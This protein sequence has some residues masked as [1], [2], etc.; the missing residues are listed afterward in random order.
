[1]LG[2]SRTVSSLCPKVIKLKPSDQKNVCNW[3]LNNQR[4]RPSRGLI[5]PPR[6]GRVWSEIGGETCARSSR[7][8]EDCLRNPN[9]LNLNSWLPAEAMEKS[10][11]LTEVVLLATGSF[12]PITVMHLRLFELARDYLHGTGRYKVV[13]GIIS[14]VSDGYKKKG[15]VE[16]S[17]RLTM[18]QLAAESS[19]WIEVDVW[20]CSQKEWTETVL[21]HHQQQQQQLVCANSGR[22]QKKP[23]SRKGHKRKRDNSCQDV[24]DYNCP[25]SKATPQVKLLCGADMLESLGTPNLWKPE[26]VVEIVSSFG[27]VCIARLGSDARKFIYESDVLWKYKDN[28]HLVEEWITN[29]ISST[30]VRR[31]LRRGLSVRYLVPD[32]VL[33]YIQAH[34]LYNEESEEKNSG[35]ILEPLVRN[36]K[37]PQNM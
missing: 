35:V 15:L 24:T 6:D 22:N 4:D 8:A 29:D 9:V 30:K 17:H 3:L 19:D 11:N 33:D 25:E 37:N 16:G 14:P 28:I 2:L 26:H 1:M 32:P 13:K 12:N 7:W 36:N 21:A 5:I 23:G 27:L 31:A 34:D 10:D 18:A 20:E